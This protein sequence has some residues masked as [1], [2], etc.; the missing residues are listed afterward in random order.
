[1]FGRFERRV[2]AHDEGPP[3]SRLRVAAVTL[4][5]VLAAAGM[6]QL[7]VNGLAAGPAGVP[8]VGLVGF[9][10]GA[11]LVGVATGMRALPVSGRRQSADP[12]PE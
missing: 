9:G 7:A 11:G 1:M 2:V 4:G 3:T 6:V 12:L 10:A 8:L 5:V